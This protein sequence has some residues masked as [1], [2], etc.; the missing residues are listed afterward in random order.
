M[1]RRVVSWLCLLAAT[2]LAQAP[3]VVNQE[4][5]YSVPSY[6]ISNDKLELAVA[7]RGGALRRLLIQGDLEKLSPFGNPEK[8]TPQPLAGQGPQVLGHFVCVD[9]FGPVSPEEAKAGMAGH[10]EAR[11][12]P[13][14]IVSSAKQ[15]PNT[16]VKFSV[17]WMT[18]IS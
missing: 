13:W 10:G 12:W 1:I 17:N 11:A 16:T 8:L 3:S 14:E 4:T 5:V 15:A 9:G 7:A 2:M 18:A 6:I